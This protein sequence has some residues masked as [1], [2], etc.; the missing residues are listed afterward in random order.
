MHAIFGGFIAGLIVP[1]ERGFDIALVEKMEDIVS[2]LFIPLVGAPLLGCESALNFE[3]YFTLSG[4]K[5]DFSYLNT[6]RL[7]PFLNRWLLTLISGHHLCVNITIPSR[8]STYASAGGYVVLI[9]VVAFFGKFV[10]CGVSAKLC[11][12]DW[13]ESATIGMLMSCKG[14][15]HHHTLCCLN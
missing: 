15:V 10:G 3:Q 13:R 2:L 6:V 5:T 14:C 1:H 11:G 8:A 7:I 9:C 12:F 4:L